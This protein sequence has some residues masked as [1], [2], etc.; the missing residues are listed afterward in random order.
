[1][2][3]LTKTAIDEPDPLKS[4]FNNHVG[5]GPYNAGDSLNFGHEKFPQEQQRPCFDKGDHIM[6][7]SNCVGHLYAGDL[8]DLPTNR[9]GLPLLGFDENIRGNRHGFPP[10]LW[11]SGLLDAYQVNTSVGLALINLF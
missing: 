7:A 5:Q 2:R 1:M 4:S 8:A 9:L 6:G 11:S 3:I 10:S